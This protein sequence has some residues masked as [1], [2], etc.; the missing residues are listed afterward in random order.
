MISNKGISIIISS[1]CNYEELVI[2][3]Y[4]NG[5]YIALLNQDNGLKDIVI[6]FPDGSHVN[7]DAVVSSLPLDIFEQGLKMAKEKLKLNS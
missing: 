7:K 5:K 3:I 6:E 2:E 4:Y 1:D